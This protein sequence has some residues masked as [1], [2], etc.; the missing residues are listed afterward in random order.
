M[1]VCFSYFLT[2]NTVLSIQECMLFFALC[3]GLWQCWGLC[4]ISW[5]CVWVDARSVSFYF[6]YILLA[7]VSIYTCEGGFAG[8]YLHPLV[9]TR[10]A[11]A[12]ALQLHHVTHT[13]TYN[14]THM[15]TQKHIL[16]LVRTFAR[17]NRG[18]LMT[19]AVVWVWNWSEGSQIWQRGPGVWD[20]PFRPVSRHYLPRKTKKVLFAQ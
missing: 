16:P 13:Y 3:G 8:G 19:P 1:L 7:C 9:C 5:Q 6:I 2:W 17:I 20:L 11:I 14:H 10:T 18:F 15:C 4:G 12:Q